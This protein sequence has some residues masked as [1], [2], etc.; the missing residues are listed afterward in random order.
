VNA[1]PK[2]VL[3][4]VRGMA[5]AGVETWLM[6]ALRRLDPRRL[7]FDF[8][9]HTSARCVFDDEIE[10]R[11]CRLYRL[12]MALSSPAYARQVVRLLREGR[13][14]A[15]HS[16]V[17]YFSGYLMLLARLAGI[18]QRIAHSHS[19]TASAE[20]GAGWRRLAYTGLMRHWIGRHATHLVAASGMAGQSL[21]DR[22]WNSDPRSRL[23]YCGI[24][25][26]PFRAAPDRDRARAEWNFRPGEVVLGHVGRFDGPKNQEFMV[27]V[28]R[29]ALRFDKSVR[30]LLVGDGPLRG[31]VE[32]LVRQ[33]GIDG[34]VV[35][36]GVRSDVP[37]LLSAM[38]AFLFPSRYEGLGL[39]LIEAQACG[40]PCVVSD[41]IP[42]EADV[43]ASLIRR[44]PLSAGARAWAES[45]LEAPRA[46]AARTAKALEA[47]AASSF[48]ISR[49]VE[50]LCELYEA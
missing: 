25:L 35:F 37:R 6:Q 23:L 11:A 42:A 27:E 39:T 21:F 48:T 45:A 7:Q 10:S 34:Q 40:L 8:L 29:E 18:P 20:C 28:A 1:P 38:D 15:I 4:V 41:A 9:V 14:D 46:S 50:G 44:L 49:S 30:L 16:H 33:A 32:E 3:H 5:R 19:C 22:R 43:D 17:H 36:T 13:Y 31:R 24:D 12:P 47:V 2:R 26:E